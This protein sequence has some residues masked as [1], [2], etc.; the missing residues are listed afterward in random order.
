ML[1]QLLS[2]VKNRKEYLTRLYDVINTNVPAYLGVGISRLPVPAEEAKTTK[3]YSVSVFKEAFDLRRI[4]KLPYENKY[5]VEKSL[6]EGGD[7]KVLKLNTVPHD[8]ASSNIILTSTSPWD[9]NVA[10]RV[11]KG[12]TDKELFIE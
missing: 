5:L 11:R 6:D 3:R 1:T 9:A 2:Q 12:A 4:T 7:L 8:S 10:V